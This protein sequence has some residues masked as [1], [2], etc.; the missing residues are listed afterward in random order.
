MQKKIT[1]I[2]PTRERAATLLHAMRTC[3][4]QDYDQLQILVSDNASEDETRDVVHSFSDSRIRYVNPGRRVSMVENFEFAFSHV[5]DGYVVSI[6]DDDGLALGGIH[7]ANELIQATQ[8]QAIVSDFAQY[9]WPNIETAAANQLMFSPRKG[10]EMRS[11]QKGLHQVLYRRH[12][13]NHLPCIYYGFIDTHLINSLRAKQEGKLF[14]TSVVDVYTAVALTAHL[15]Q[16]CFSF[17]PLTIN[18]TSGRSNGASFMRISTDDSEK[19]RWY[20]ENTVTRQAP[21]Y[22]SGGIKMLLAEACHA[23]QQQIP[24]ALPNGAIDYD[25]LLQQS[26]EDLVL[27]PKFGF[28]EAHILSLARDF[29]A[30]VHSPGLH[31][32]LK[33]KMQLYEDRAPKFLR[34]IMVN[35]ASHDAHDVF[36]AAHLMAK[37]QSEP[38]FV[39]WLTKFPMLMKRFFAVR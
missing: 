37:M 34:G 13:F 8:A 21:F 17:E 31:R 15:E 29:G 3:V 19:K 36:A 24:D 28:D 7:K 18:G 16:Y 38:I 20:A 22:A 23:L 12:P 27:Y 6:G 33:A 14:M 4:A 10:Y 11:G 2:I 25:E 30:D 5:T 26:I 1:V 9:M 32:K 35:A 39:N